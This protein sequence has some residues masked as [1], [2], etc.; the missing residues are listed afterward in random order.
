MCEDVKAL[1]GREPSVVHAVGE[2][3]AVQAAAVF[4]LLADPTRIRI[5]ALLSDC[6]ELT[7]G[8]LAGLIGRK[9]TIVSQHLSKLRLAKVVVGRQEGARVHYRLLE[10]HPG[11]LVRQALMQV[12]HMTQEHPAHHRTASGASAPRAAAAPAVG[13]SDSV[14]ALA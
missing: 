7:V 4:K 12:E 14:E 9:P 11:E 5:V 1:V 13:A 6:G 8:E 3:R 10:E 2:D